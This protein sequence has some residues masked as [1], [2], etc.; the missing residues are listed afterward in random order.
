M[1]ILFRLLC[2]FILIFGLAN[3]ALAQQDGPRAYVLTPKGVH[4]AIFGTVYVDANQTPANGPVIVDSDISSLVALPLYAHPIEVAGNVG[5]IF[6]AQPVGSVDGSVDING[7]ITSNG[8]SGL[9]D[10]SFGAMIGLVGM[11]AM[12]VEE[13][14][15]YKPGFSMATVLAVSAPT[16]D[17]DQNQI[18]NLGQN[19]WLFR[20]S[21]PMVFAFGESFAD[22][23]L[24][25]FELTPA[26]TFFGDNDEPFGADKQSQKPLY[27]LE[28]HLTRTLNNKTWISAD[29]GYFYGAEGSTDGVSDDNARMNFNLGATVSYS[30][31]P[32]L[33]LQLSYAHSIKSNDYGMKG[34]G[35][36]LMLIAPF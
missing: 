12:T 14:L 4:A 24:M 35:F 22:P 19:R 33:Q 30:L 13:Y 16:G 32:A 25:T 9:G 29:A 7:Q 2:A 28:A 20:A 11:P 18:F 5:S 15:A 21:L 26:V 10:F 1:S 34:E 3:V 6:V 8:S 17:Y 36:R 27:Q 31:S 23:K